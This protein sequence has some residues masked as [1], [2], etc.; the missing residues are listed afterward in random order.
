M[1]EKTTDAHN[2]GADLTFLITKQLLQ[3][4]T[5]KTL[6]GAIN[7]ACGEHISTSQVRGTYTEAVRK[8]ITVG[9]ERAKSSRMKEKG[10]KGRENSKVHRSQKIMYWRMKQKF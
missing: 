3:K 8:Q 7:P 6:M 4:A 5:G 2:M 10:L 9:M 1:L